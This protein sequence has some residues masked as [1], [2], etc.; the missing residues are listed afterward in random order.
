[1]GVDS[2]GGRVATPFDTAWKFT[3]KWE[4]GYSNHPS[5]PG[6]STMY[7]ITQATYTAWLNSQGLPP[8]DVRDMPKETAQEIAKV[9]YWDAMGLDDIAERDPQLAIALFDWGFHSGVQNVINRTEGL[10]TANEV[11]D[12][13]MEFL[14]QLSN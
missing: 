3:S 9:R 6:G 10:T 11:M 7:G 12:A 8:G 14:T 4:G 13:R 5:D 2:N 1:M